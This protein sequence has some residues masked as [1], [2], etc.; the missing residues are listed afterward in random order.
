MVLRAWFENPDVQRVAAELSDVRARIAWA[1]VP[2][3]DWQI[4][5]R[6]G[7]SPIHISERLVIAPP[8][9]AP[10]DALIIEPGQGFGTG[11]HPT[12]VQMLR[13][14][15]ELADS[16]ASALDIGCG[17]GILALAAASLGLR[18]RG[19]DIETAAIADAK[20]NAARN[21][22]SATFST[23]PIE[24]LEGRADLVLANLHAELISHFA[25]NLERLT[26][27][28]L[29]LAGILADREPIARAAL[30]ECLTLTERHVDG[31]WVS[32]RYRR[33]E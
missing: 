18:A 24:D 32:L 13:A 28:W 6:A 5:W 20:A 16:S 15:D 21:A 1:V 30:D 26:G 4:A 29:I 3:T 17:S 31:E 33:V 23:T 11:S 22:L 8:W 2:D 27:E 9:N 12:T 19:V 7:F 10:E 25:G 14:I